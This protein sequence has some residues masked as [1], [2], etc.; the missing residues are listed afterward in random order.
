MKANPAAS[1]ANRDDVAALPPGTVLEGRYRLERVLG[2]GG[3]SIVY[4]AEDDRF[5]RKVAIKEYLPA[6]VATRSSSH[7]VVPRSSREEAAFDKGL[8]RFRAE[9]AL[10]ASFDQ[11]NVVR[12]FDGFEA[13]GTAY[14]VMQYYEGAETLAEAVRSARFTPRPDQVM[15]LF[16]TLCAALEEVHSRGLVHRDVAPDNVLILADGR[17]VLIDFGGARDCVGAA[18]Q[19][20]EALRKPG[21]SPIEQYHSSLSG[22]MPEV[23][24]WSDIYALSA[25]IY[26]LIAGRP[27]EEA[28]AR[29][30]P[31]RLKPLRE[32]TA[33]SDYPAAF[34]E[35]V[36]AGLALNRQKRP[37]SIGEL[38]AL[39]QAGARRR[40]YVKVLVGVLL[41]AMVIGLAG[42][43][44]SE[45][46]CAPPPIAQPEPPRPDPV[47][48]PA[49]EPV[50]DEAVD[51]SEVEGEEA[52]IDC[53][54]EAQQRGQKD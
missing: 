5:R 53:L 37:Q 33:A 48:E 19:S 28:P 9:G 41:A 35:A 30:K 21:Y 46:C 18:S 34:I 54:L 12:V 36:W 50:P 7:S 23:G 44:Y 26:W 3:F 29:V 45:L 51:C 32:V 6:A 4:L 10:L 17:P 11:P 25:V 31:D 38:T 47:P 20:I 24:A 22:D 16:D 43:A 40:P 52:V 49:P 13:Y 39:V 15:Q 42:W 2:S 8:E 1:S 27:P 14:L